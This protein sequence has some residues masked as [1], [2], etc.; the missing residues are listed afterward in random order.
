M[1]EEGIGRSVGTKGVLWH[2]SVQGLCKLIYLGM[3]GGS[4]EEE[5]KY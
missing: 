3:E 4:K 5:R 2:H 1:V